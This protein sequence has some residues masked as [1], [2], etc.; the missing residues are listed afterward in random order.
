MQAVT[1]ATGL[2]KPRSDLTVAL[3]NLGEK[4]KKLLIALSIFTLLLFSQLASVSQAALVGPT[5]SGTNGSP[6]SAFGN[7][8]N[9]GVVVN[10]QSDSILASINSNSFP[11]ATGTLSWTGTELV[12]VSF[13]YNI[14]SSNPGAIANSIIYGGNFGDPSR[15]FVFAGNA[16]AHISQIFNLSDFDSGESLFVQAAANS[17]GFASIT[18][19]SVAAPVPVP[20]AV[21]LLGSGLVGLIGLNRRRRKAS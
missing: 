11:L 6:I 19:L 14:S 9:N 16:S 13:D 18:N 12:T 21:W 17:T 15:Y 10:I 2:N 1:P 8:N 20:A 5:V 4:M 3:R 7:Y